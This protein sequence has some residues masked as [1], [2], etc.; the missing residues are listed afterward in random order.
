MKTP[1]ISIITPTLNVES[2]ISNTLNSITN[3]VYKN[4]E[5]IIIDANSNDNT[6]EIIRKY[7]SLIPISFISEP[8]NGISDAFNKGVNLSK[9]KWIIFLGAGDELI[10]NKI[11]KLIQFINKHKKKKT[12]E[13]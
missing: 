6:L 1:F 7:S 3:Q 9:G 13:S 4:Y 11:L 10:N 5:Y 8:D 2:T 12:N